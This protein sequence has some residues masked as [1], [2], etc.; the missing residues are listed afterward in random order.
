MQ[1]DPFFL[2]YMATDAVTLELNQVVHGDF[3]LLAQCHVPLRALLYARDRA[4]LAVRDAS[5]ISVTDGSVV[6]SA[7][8][9]VRLALPVAELF[10][11]Y[12]QVRAAHC[13]S[14]AS[15]GGGRGGACADPLA[16]ACAITRAGQPR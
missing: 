10:E 11:M 5:L 15:A 12:L 4:R 2:R 1:T 8:V 7:H 9:E 6:G 13:S 3:V 14:S 16:D